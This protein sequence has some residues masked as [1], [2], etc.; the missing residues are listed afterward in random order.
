MQ[1]HI[2]KQHV[3]S[4]CSK[5]IKKMI[6]KNTMCKAHVNADFKKMHYQ[7]LCCIQ[8]VGVNSRFLF[9][10]VMFWVVLDFFKIIGTRLAYGL[11]LL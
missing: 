6:K 3:E 10:L 5:M 8:M 1:F 2:L 11:Y 4:F 7:E 9:A